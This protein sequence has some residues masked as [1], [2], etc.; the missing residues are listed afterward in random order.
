M[1]KKYLVFFSSLCYNQKEI[2]YIQETKKDEKQKDKK[3]QKKQAIVYINTTKF[4]NNNNF[5]N[6]YNIPKIHT[7]YNNRI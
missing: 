3:K 6:L 7:I 5:I 2:F 1:I 4:F